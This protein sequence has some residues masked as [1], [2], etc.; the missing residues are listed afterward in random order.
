MDISA[1]KYPIY[2]VSKGRYETPLTAKIFLKEKIPFKIVVEPFEYEK[3]CNAVGSENV[4]VLPF[5]NLG[6]GSYPARNFCW[7]HSIQNGYARHWV[8]D[9]NIRAFSRLNKG[10]RK[11]TSALLSIIT[12]ETLTDRYE[13]V[14]I[15]AFNYRYFVNRETKNPFSINTHCYSGMLIRN[16]IPFRWRLKYNEDVDLC[17][18]VLDS[19][20]CTILLNAFLIDKTSTTVK[21]KGGNQE[22]LYKNNSF[23]KKVLKAKSLEKIWEHKDYVKTVIRFNRPH[24]FV[25]WKK[26]FT[27]PLIKKI[28]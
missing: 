8:F 27:H 11:Q 23:D 16:D 18:Q 10:L 20:L 3:Y 24:H 9:D 22:E 17:L 4:L 7:E 1:I 28:I 19:G 14:A 6:L 12:L 26:Y 5:E 15:S 2:I 25:D 21:M 13:N